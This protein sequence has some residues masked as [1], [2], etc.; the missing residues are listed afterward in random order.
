MPTPRA[1]STIAL[2]VGYGSDAAKVEAILREAALG[3]AR[4]LRVPAPIVRFARLGADG[5]EFDLFAFVDRL[6]DR[7][8]V[9]NDL[10]RAILQKLREAEIEIPFRTVDLHLRDIDRLVQAIRRRGRQ[11]R[12]P[13]ASPRRRRPAMAPRRRPGDAPPPALAARPPVRAGRA[14]GRGLVGLCARP[15]ARVADRALRQRPL[16]VHRCRRRARPCPRPGQPRRHSDGAD[17]RLGRL[18]ARMGGLG[19]AS[20]ASRRG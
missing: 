4:V 6:E 11:R 9:G 12:P 7:L 18:A 5:L 1:G 19:R 13:A 20:W 15:A 2:T 14:G 17:P 8:V 16:E 10:N 3:H